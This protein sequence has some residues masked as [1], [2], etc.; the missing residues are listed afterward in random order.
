MRK[1][2]SSGKSAEDNK[3]PGACSG[4]AAEVIPS[5]YDI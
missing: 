4:E 1:A 2:K 5:I 3:E